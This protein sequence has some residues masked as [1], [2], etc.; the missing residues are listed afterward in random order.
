MTFHLFL[1]WDHLPLFLWQII[2]FISSHTE[3]I[4]LFYCD[5]IW[6]A[7]FRLHFDSYISYTVT[8]CLFFCDKFDIFLYWDHLPLFLWQILFAICFS[9]IFIYWDHLPLF[10]VTNLM[11]Y[12]FFISSY[13]ETI[14]LFFCDKTLPAGSAPHSEKIRLYFCDKWPFISS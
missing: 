4:Y 9:N 14:C 3:T 6:F 10:F 8:I 13:T 2:E 12:I 11:L 7:R 1:T 5:K